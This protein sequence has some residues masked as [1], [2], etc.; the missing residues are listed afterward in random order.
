MAICA[1]WGGGVTF[2][3]LNPHHKALNMDVKSRASDGE[4]EGAAKAKIKA[5]T[6]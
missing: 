1:V 6:T 4:I 5:I 3:T 2:C